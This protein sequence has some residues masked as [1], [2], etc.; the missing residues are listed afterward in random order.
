MKLGDHAI[1]ASGM[2]EIRKGMYDGEV[3]A[4]K[5]LRLHGSKGNGDAE[6]R[7]DFG[8]PKGDSDIT[9]VKRVSV[10]YDPKQGPC[11]S[12]C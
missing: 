6:A 5:V 12:F 7:K 4:L 8:F 2:T 10:L 11:L 1:R 9:T 3:V